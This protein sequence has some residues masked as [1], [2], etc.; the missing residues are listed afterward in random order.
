[1]SGSLNKKTWLA[2]EEEKYGKYKSINRQTVTP[3][4]IQEMFGLKFNTLSC[5]IEGAELLL[6]DKLYEHFKEYHIMCVEF[7]GWAK[8]KGVSRD[9]IERMYSRDFNIER[10]GRM[11]LFKK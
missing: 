7:H 8:A 10:I 1:M 5:D 4:D 3:M 9:N 6:L 2:N 11:T